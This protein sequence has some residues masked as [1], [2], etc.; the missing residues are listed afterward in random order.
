M[1]KKL[2]QIELN[3]ENVNLKPVEPNLICS[4]CKKKF[5]VL[6][7][8]YNQKLCYDCLKLYSQYKGGYIE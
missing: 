4:S 1:K 6:T 2:K 7:I 3:E 5:S 8:E